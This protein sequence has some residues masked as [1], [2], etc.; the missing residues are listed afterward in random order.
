MRANNMKI[1]NYV[2]YYK[3]KLLA[4]S[5]AQ[6]YFSLGRRKNKAGSETA[7]AKES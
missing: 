6:S 7:E 2:L 5:D 3:N 4:F 1:N